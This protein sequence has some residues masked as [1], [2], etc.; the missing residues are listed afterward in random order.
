MSHSECEVM[1]FHHPAG[2]RY[3]NIAS[4]LKC[5][6]AKQFTCL[7]PFFNEDGRVLQVLNKISTLRRQAEII[8]I[9]DGSQDQAWQKI[10]KRYPWVNLIRLKKNQGKT[11]AVA[12]GLKKVKT[13]YVFLLDAD[14]R[15]ISVKDFQAGL[16]WCRKQPKVDMLIFGRINDPFRTDLLA[17][18]ILLSGERIVKTKI[19]KA[20]LRGRVKGFQLELALNQYCLDHNLTVVTL[21]SRAKTT[22]KLKKYGLVGL[23]RDGKMFW[24][25]FNYTGI[26]SYMR[27]VSVFTGR[28]NRL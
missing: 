27:Q 23:K 13:P 17:T 3:F 21:P 15:K 6:M 11:G 5:L 16:D 14:L 18:H 8:C 20:V 1:P 22:L 26:L 2:Q 19:L 24:E 28:K 25:L 9:D 10:V 4:V 12:A 7:I